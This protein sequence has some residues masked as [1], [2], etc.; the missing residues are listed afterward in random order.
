[1]VQTPE[2]YAFCS[3][4]PGFELDDVPQGLKPQNLGDDSCAPEG[5]PLQRNTK[6]KSSAA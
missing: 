1:L 3:A 6:T 2:E 4:F 5:A